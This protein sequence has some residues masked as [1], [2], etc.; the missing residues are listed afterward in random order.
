MRIGRYP[1]TDVGIWAFEAIEDQTSPV[2][3]TDHAFY[4]FRL[5]SL[6]SEGIAPLN[7]I[8]DRVTAE[9]KAAKKWVKAEELARLVDADLKGGMALVNAAIKYGLVPTAL[10]SFTRGQPSPA[11]G[12]APEALGVAFGLAVDQVSGPI[13]TEQAIFFIQP[14]G[15]H[16]ADSTAFAAG[17]DDFRNQILQQARQIRVQLM[18]AAIRDNAKVV[19]NRKALARAQRAQPA[20]PFGQSPLPNTLG[21]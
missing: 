17:L 14:T 19:D 10:K 13:K 4:V 15:R 20:L 21:F 5:D 9:A 11:L 16:R 8:R 6:E 1:V 2:I 3:E 18:V 7:E 12:G